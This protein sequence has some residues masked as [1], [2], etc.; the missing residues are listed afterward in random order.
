[1]V[2]QWNKA[3]EDRKKIFWKHYNMSKH[4]EYYSE[5]INK[6]TPLIP[7]KFRMEEIEGE[8]E[9]S[10]KIRTRLCLQRFQAHIEI[11]E[12]N[13]ENHKLGYLNID[14]HMIELISETRKD[15]IKASLRQMLEDECKEDEKD[16]EKAW[17]EKGNWLALYESKYGVSFF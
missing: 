13:S 10:K 15:N 1:M 3:R 9:R 11:M 8:N 6:E 17:E 4:I 2:K 7:L 16:Q 5:W 12:V 14:K